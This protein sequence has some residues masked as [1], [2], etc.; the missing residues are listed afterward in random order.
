MCA[1]AALRL[2]SA[3][4]SKRFHWSG[5]GCR[6]ST[7]A[8]SA[9]CSS[10]ATWLQSAMQ[11]PCALSLL[12]HAARFILHPVRLVSSTHDNGHGRPTGNAM[13]GC[14]TK[15]EQKVVGLTAIPTKYD[16]LTAIPTKYDQA[17][18]PSL[19]SFRMQQGVSKPMKRQF[20]DIGQ[21]I[22]PRRSPF[23]L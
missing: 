20:E 23:V 8:A 12:W 3:L 19:L 5:S 16:H 7:T 13:H 2:V 4:T 14:K 17:A 22:G 1:W 6:P 15:Q 11:R 21:P 9:F 10:S 18:A